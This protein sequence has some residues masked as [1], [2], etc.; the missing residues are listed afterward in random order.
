[1][2]RPTAA[3]IPLP[4]KELMALVTGD[5]YDQ[6]RAFESAGS[7]VAHLATHV[8]MINPGARVLDIGCG[9]GRVAR[10]L[11]AT[12]I[13]SYVGFDRHAGMIAWARANVTTHDPRFT[14]EHF[15]IRSALDGI[16]GEAGTVDAAEFRFPYADGSFDSILLASVF[17]QMPLKEVAAYLSEIRRVLAPDGRVLLSVFMSDLRPM[18]DETGRV[19]M[20][21]L[22]SDGHTLPPFSVP[23][24]PEVF[25]ALFFATG[26]ASTVVA[27]SGSHTWCTLTQRPATATPV[28]AAPAAAA[29]LDAA[30]APAQAPTPV[31]MPTADAE[32][33]VANDRWFYRFRL[34]N[35]QETEPFGPEKLHDDR[36]TML[37]EVL[38]GEFGPDWGALSCLDIAC[39]QGWFAYNL[40]LRR[41]GRVL[42]VDARPENIR[43]AEAIRD[44]CGL[45]NLDFA[46]LDVNGGGLS[47]LEA[48]DVVVMYGLIYHLEDPIG[49][50][51]AATR[52]ARRLLVIETQVLNYNVSG[53][54]DWGRHQNVIPVPAIFGVIEEPD[55]S[56]RQNGVTGF[57]LV[58]SREGLVWLLR[59]LGYTSVEVVAPP[60]GAYDQL[61]TGKRIVVVARR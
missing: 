51:R 53:S 4:P 59:A 17:T 8:G 46:V 45:T 61:A 55:L 32:Q 35:G 49:A 20:R 15:P 58:P 47:S 48:A 43:S 54:I 38:A 7:E 2:D 26:F 56:N 40:A 14:F 25:E 41:F 37:L 27:E 57:A 9:V 36:L 13:G 12:A 1:M 39:N 33:R 30:A 16:D 10:H 50:L 42:G 31:P 21:V 52:L 60:P 24:Q 5:H 11:V 34:P 19:V 23:Y 6:A 29:P 22:L 3:H 28:A 18:V 44:L